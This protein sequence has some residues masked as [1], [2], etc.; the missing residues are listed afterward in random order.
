V[1]NKQPRERPET[2]YTGPNVYYYMDH[3]Q[4]SAKDLATRCLVD[5]LHSS[6]HYSSMHSQRLAPKPSRASAKPVL[7]RSIGS[8]AAESPAE[9]SQL[10]IRQPSA[11]AGSPRQQKSDLRCAGIQRSAGPASSSRSSQAGRQGSSRARGGRGRRAVAVQQAQEVHGRR[12]TP[13]HRTRPAVGRGRTVAPEL[14]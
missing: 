5:P 7:N 10:Q 4:L 8:L 2:D 13:P 12:R 9:I 1:T 14:L 3:A 6:R 11:L